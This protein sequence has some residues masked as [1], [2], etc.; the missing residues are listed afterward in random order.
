MPRITK[1]DWIPKLQHHKSSGRAKV[2]LNGQTV[3]LGRYG[4]EEAVQEY[5]RVVALWKA[6]QA[7]SKAPRA[8]GV[9]EGA[10]ITEVV[11]A[12]WSEAQTIY[13]G[14]ST[15]HKVRKAMGHLRKLC[16]AMVAADFGAPMLEAY[17]QHLI[18]HGLARTSIND[19]TAVIRRMFRFAVRKRLAPA[20]VL[21]E[22]SAVDG[23]R[24]GR[25]EA[26][27][28]DPV[29]PVPEPTIEATIGKAPQ[30][31]GD[32]IRLQLLTGARPGEIVSMR[33]SEIDTSGPTWIY[34]PSRHK[35]SW[36]GK[37]R[38]I[39][40]GPRAQKI[41]RPYL[42]TELSEPIFSPAR[43][44]EMRLA[45]REAARATSLKYGNRRGTN[46]VRRRQRPP[47]DHYTVNSYRRAIERACDRAFPPPPPLD[48]LPASKGKR[49]ES[50]ANRRARLT[51]EQWAE[52]EA[53]RDAHRWNPNQLRHTRA[54]EVRRRYGIEAAS[55][56]LGHSRLST[57]EIYAE[58]CLKQ[59][60][61]V[62]A[63]VG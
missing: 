20:I 59:A 17:Q 55:A 24:A 35:L 43:S 40:I 47:K 50:E 61:K 29:R 6:G 31:V 12:Y 62:A 16:G 5:N 44:E 51:S 32:M 4:S 7:V 23:L 8:A 11:I 54:T 15:L 45:A 1:P 28:P 56:V 13:S 46:R 48:F 14:T 38:Q 30:M 18:G 63:E 37:V 53:W 58:K 52:L 42:R 39:A 9:H 33:T 26:R 22:L 60:A 34:T 21:H 25:S 41:L 10:T 49:R 36:K 2:K 3:W 19:Y 27:E 57:T